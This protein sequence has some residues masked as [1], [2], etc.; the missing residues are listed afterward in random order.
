M[1]D[2]ETEIEKRK[3]TTFGVVFLTIFLDMVGFSVIFPLFPAMLDHYL[4]RESLLGGGLLTDFVSSL[5]GLA[6]EGDVLNSDFRFETVIF[7]GVLGSLYAILQFFFAPIWGGFS[8]KIGRRPVLLMTLLG[9]CIG[10]GLWIFAGG[11]WVLVL[12]RVISGIASGNLSVA[13]ASIADVT[14]RESRSKGMAFVGVAFGLGFIFGPALGGWASQFVLISQSES[15]F[16]LNPFSI[17]ATISFLLALVNICWLFYSFKETLH[18]NK[19]VEKK[20][21]KPVIFQ[22]RKIKSKAVKDSC[23]AYLFYMISFSGMEFTLTFL[24]VERF[25]YNPMQITKMFLLIGVTLIF[26]QGFFV[27]RFV[28]RVGEK[29]MAILGIFIGLVA[30]FMLSIVKSETSF[31]ISLFLMSTGVAFISPTL[32]SLTSLHSNENDQGLHLG[33]FRSSGSMARAI[34]PLLAGLIFFKYGSS[35]AYFLGALFLLIPFWFLCRV[36][37]PEN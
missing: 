10:Y 15:D 33:V 5:Q 8:D 32:T 6:F 4:E 36:P 28:G 17:A 29:R 27:R 20:D 11:F 7:G 1:I 22:L 21:S 2:T 30:F 34:G 23:L 14:T 31:Y 18:Q 9:T 13:T 19:R 35:F 16:G 37:Q 25:S 12:S 24:A 3:K 26:A